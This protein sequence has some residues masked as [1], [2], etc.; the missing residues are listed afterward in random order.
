[1]TLLQTEL[2]RIAIHWNKH[3]TRKQK[4]A[5]AQAGKPDVLFY[6]PNLYGS[7]DYGTLVDQNDVSTCKRLYGSDR[8]ACTPE[9]VELVE[10]LRPGTN[11]PTDVES[12]IDLYFLLS[13]II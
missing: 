6:C 7:R 8:L 1:M 4:I 3:S 12:A 13:N 9:F 5:E 10:I 2:D 11:V